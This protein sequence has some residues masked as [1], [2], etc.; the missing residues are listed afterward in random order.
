[1]QRLLLLALVATLGCA[2]SPGRPNDITAALKARKQ[3]TREL[4]ARGDLASA[5]AYADEL[6]RQRPDDA[7]VLTLRGII[8]RERNMPAEAEA[9]LRAALVADNRNADAHAA[10]GILLDSSGR[11][12]DAEAHHRRAVALDGR[13]ATYLNNLGFSLLVQRKARDAIDVLQRAARLDPM[14]RRIR[15][16]L[17]FAHAAAGDLPRAAREFEMGGTPAEA[18]N[19]LGF[20]YEHRGDRGN[21]FDLYVAALRLDP[22]CLRAR[23]NLGHIAQALGREIPA[24]ISA[25][26]R[27]A[28][29]IQEVTP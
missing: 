25:S 19:N 3:L 4:V 9:D 7:E 14:N 23:N 5:F 1:M 26:S 8:F 10:L 28:K 20:A 29:N 11:S 22:D 13:S 2:S 16:N 18:K 15:T 17:G 27:P 12:G 21:A 6:H 24:D